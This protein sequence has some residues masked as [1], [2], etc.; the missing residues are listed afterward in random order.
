MAA[1]IKGNGNLKFPWL[2]MEKMYETID[3]IQA[4]P[5]LFCSHHFQYNGPMPPTLPKWML[6]TYELYARDPRLVL[7]QQLAMPEFTDKFNPIPYHRFKST[8]D[9]VFSNLMSGDWAWD[10]A[11]MHSLVSSIYD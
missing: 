2:S 5:A 7:Q 3:Q 11:V 1:K 6:E 4:G 9:R 8:R 10:Q